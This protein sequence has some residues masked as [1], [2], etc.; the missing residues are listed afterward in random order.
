MKIFTSIQ[1]KQIDQYTIDNEPITSIDLMERASLVFVDWFVKYFPDTDR[2]VHL[3]CGTGNN[4]GDGLAVGRLLYRRFYNVKITCCKISEETSGDFQINL[5][6]LP[7]FNA[8][9]VSELYK[10]SSFPEFKENTVIIDAIF[11]SGLNRIVD[12]YWADFFNHLNNSGNSIV[13]IDIPSGLFADQNTTGHSIHADYTFSFEYPKLAFFFPQNLEIVGHWF[14]NT[15]GL[16]KTALGKIEAH[17]FYIDQKMAKSLLR[18]RK[19]FDHKGTFGHTLIVG[20]SYGKM[21]AVVLSVKAALRSGAG[22]V[23][24]LVPKCG[25]E[26][27]QI[28]CPEAMVL[29]DENQHYIS[30]IPDI[31]KY[32]AVGMGI[33]LDTT[34][35]TLGA[36][37]KLL[38]TTTLPLV[39]DADALNLVAHNKTLLRQIPENSI[40]TPHPKEFE[41]LF[42]KGDNNFDTNELQ[43]KMAQQYRIFI[44]LKGANTCIATPDGYCYFNSTGS[45][46]LATGGSGDVLTGMI[47]GLLAQGYTPKNAAIL[48]VYLHGKTGELAAKEQQSEES[49]IAGDLVN[50]IGKAISSIY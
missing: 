1:T 43:R 44:V 38:A 11:G 35:A 46:A 31:G 50:C 7:D 28:S 25:Y 16:H 45:P 15:I 14:Y 21:G 29:M 30:D 13:S 2:L 12:G 40:L 42:G 20:G 39:L 10:N 33:G 17:N 36:L 24:C 6:R 4:G 23:T 34:P 37:K 48:G 19:K 49:V 18:K 32:R 27:M 26:I 47:T 9:P 41:R 22:L 8:I 5:K 3:L